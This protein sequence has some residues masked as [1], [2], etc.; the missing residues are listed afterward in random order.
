MSTEVHSPKKSIEQKLW[1]RYDMALWKTWEDGWRVEYVF[2]GFCWMW[3]LSTYSKH[4]CSDFHRQHIHLTCLKHLIGLA[5][6][7]WVGILAK[8]HINHWPNGDT[9]SYTYIHTYY[10]IHWKSS[11]GWS[12]TLCKAAFKSRN[13]GSVRCHQFFDGDIWQKAK[14]KKGFPKVSRGI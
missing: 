5:M 11:S 6:K 4:Q 13:S 8:N 2:D 9:C 12:P 3:M 14:N 1:R 10:L 7:K